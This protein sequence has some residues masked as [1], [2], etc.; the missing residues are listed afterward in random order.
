MLLIHHPGAALMT[1]RQGPGH[2][3]AVGSGRP[4]SKGLATEP[5]RLR[6]RPFREP[7]VRSMHQRLTP[8]RYIVGGCTGARRQDRD[9]GLACGQAGLGYREG[10]RGAGGRPPAGSPARGGQPGGTDRY[11]HLRH[12]AD[13][14]R[15]TEAV[16]VRVRIPQR[17][18][19]SA[20][21]HTRPA[22]RA[23]PCRRARR[24]ASR[25]PAGG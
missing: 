2:R 18:P 12:R 16:R 1:A 15:R 13:I 17:R 24:H 8:R 25:R 10:G 23:R 21:L 9:G 22:G 3:S 5:R 7:K 4:Q 11:G 6:G 20:L 19:I 14:G